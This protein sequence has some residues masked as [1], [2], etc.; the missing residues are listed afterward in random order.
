MTACRRVKVCFGSGDL[1]MRVVVA[2]GGTAPLRRGQ[3]TTIDSQCANVRVTSHSN[4][5]PHSDPL[6]AKLWRST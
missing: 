2:L 5:S 6:G 3:L 1:R 4:A